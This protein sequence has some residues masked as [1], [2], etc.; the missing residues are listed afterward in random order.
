MSSLKKL[1]MRGAFWAIAGY[2]A[3]QALRFIAN[4]IL[5]HLLMP[6]LFGLMALVN[7]FIVGLQLFSDIGVGPSIIQNKRGDDPDFL[8]TAW[9][10]QVCRGV[11]LWIG[12]IAIAFPIAQ[13]YEEPQ[14]MG[15]I[16]MVGLTTVI[17][18][19]NSTALFTCDRHLAV[20]QLAIFELG[21]QCIALTVMLVWAWFHPT[22][23]ALVAG[24]LLSVFIRMVWSHMLIAKHPNHFQW[25]AKAA[26]EIFSFG[27]W[28]FISTVLTFLAGQVDRLILG[29]LFSFEL[30]GIY[31]IAFTLSDLP[32]QV[33]LA[34]SNKV[35]FPTV[36]KLADLPRCE[37][38]AKILHSRK[39]MLLLLA[40]GVALLTSFGD[41]VIL[42]LYDEQYKQA[43]WM[44]P[45]LALG[46]WPNML[47]QTLDP[48]L[49]AIGKPRYVALANL[50]RFLFNLISIPVGFLLFG[51][52][53][54][55][56]FVALNDVPFYVMVTYGLWREGLSGGFQDI[57]VTLFLLGILT[58]LLAGRVLLG[59]GLPIDGL[60][61]QL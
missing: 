58:L 16:P 15:L 31:V 19:F 22:I 41:L 52:P 20:R 11:A 4:L 10:I 8:N 45:L 39:D 56:I 12:S 9:T 26:Q 61:H 43:A 18:G 24:T 28:I 17:S 30:L 5:T 50:C 21:G 23:W 60:L 35:I 38:R 51:V 1:A 36:S 57:T 13:I 29:K 55:V 54:A 46:I 33:V 40:L 7:I 2:G 6:K 47:S 49:F 27:K 32:R 37:L 48:A 14:L 53:G 34:V 59:F 44:L 3:G 42:L 25:D